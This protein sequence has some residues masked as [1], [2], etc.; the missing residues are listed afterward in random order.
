MQFLIVVVAVLLGSGYYFLNQPQF[1]SLPS[2]KR[3][4][5]IASSPNY[6]NGAF[7]NIENTPNFSEDAGLVDFIKTMFSIPENASPSV[8]L[9]SV[10]TQLTTISDTAISVVWF[11]HSSYYINLKGFKILVDPVFSGVAAPVDFFANAFDGSNDYQAEDIPPLDLL[12]L[13]HDHYDHLDYKTILKLKD[14]TKHIYTSLGV[15]AHLNHWGISDNQITEFDWWQTEQINQQLKI[16]AT[17]ARHFSGR[18]FKRNQSL[19]SSFVMEYPGGKL[20][21]GGD[22][23]YDQ[24]F[25]KIGDQFGAFDL[26]ILEC[27]QYNQ[28]WPYIHMSPEQVVQAAIDLKAKV[29]MPVHWSK[30]RLAMHKWNEPIERVCKEA[31]RLEMKITTPMIGEQVM[32]NQNYPTSSWWTQL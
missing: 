22:S 27:G 20:F 6:K 26:V 3:L 1:G 11:G 2:G 4:S 30:F 21:I 8:K 18:L 15:G 7:Q 19:W 25:K 5:R 16:T 29:L 24:T 14:K 13:T 31:S 9:P 23:G 32:V 12:I 17:P 28:L 10:K